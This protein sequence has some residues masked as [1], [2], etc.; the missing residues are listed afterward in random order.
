[1]L[2][3]FK[4]EKKWMCFL[5]VVFSF[6][7]FLSTNSY[8]QKEYPEKE[9]K[10]TVGTAG[11]VSDLWTRAW[12]DEFSKILKV[13][14]V[15]VNKTGGLT[16]QLEAKK[17]RPDGYTLAYVSQSNVVTQAVSEKPPVDL[18]K[19]LAPI[20]A[21]GSFPTL[22]VVEQSSPFQKFEDLIDYARKN[23]GKLKCGSAGILISYFNFE[24]LK[25]Y[26]K[27]DMTVVQFKGSAPASTALLGKH[28]DLLTISPSAIVGLMKAGRIRALLSTQK[29]KDFQGI[30]LFSDKG[31]EEA[32]MA[33][34]SGLFAPVGVP[35]DIQNILIDAFAKT[36]KNPEILKRMENLDYS[37][38]YTGPTQLGAQLKKDF[39]KMIPIVNELGLKQ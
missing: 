11:S 37:T 18:I 25:R 10:I 26:T 6:L 22:I 36:A 39:D 30:P 34:W 9:I 17:S 16:G 5:G 8:G 2:N 27:T 24:L 14:V 35:K 21:L 38:D 3:L 32:G 33:A 29:L 19:D 31:L 28:V 12:T 7:L 1:M 20:G 4:R 13:P 23:P 15:V